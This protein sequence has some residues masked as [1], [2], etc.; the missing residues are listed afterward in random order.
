[1][2]FHAHGVL[3]ERSQPGFLE[4]VSGICMGESKENLCS[5]RRFLI[6]TGGEYCCAESSS[7]GINNR[8][9]CGLPIRMEIDKRG[10]TQMT[11]EEST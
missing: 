9:D 4:Q 3:G 5:S 6:E 10:D 1:M 8:F 11:K 2:S 7:Q